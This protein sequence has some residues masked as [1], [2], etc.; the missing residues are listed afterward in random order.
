M[1]IYRQIIA[2]LLAIGGNVAV[3]TD[4]ELVALS[5]VAEALPSLAPWKLQDVVPSECGFAGAADPEAKSANR[6]DLE[7]ELD[8]MGS[9]EQADE[10]QR[11][12]LAEGQGCIEVADDPPITL[13]VACRS[14]VRADGRQRLFVT[15]HRGRV[16]AR[17][18]LS[19]PAVAIRPAEVKAVA[20]LAERS[21]WFADDEARLQALSHC[22]WLHGEAVQKLLGTTLFRQQAGR[23][24]TCVARSSLGSLSVV[25]SEADLA[26]ELAPG[27]S[28]DCAR[29]AVSELGEFGSFTYDCQDILGPLSRVH[30][31]VG[32]KFVEYT[33]RPGRDPTT[34]ERSLLIQVAKDA[35][36]AAK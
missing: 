5:A 2:M 31:I 10:R 32:D 4:C 11:A 7:I 14:P 1:G 22:P 8:L 29:E 26:P 6:V 36:A 17:A 27:A 25:T 16:L 21:L 34:A 28:G 12:Q 20:E 3:A 35:H 18:T 9:P 19:A 23:Y 13:A 24:E 15:T 30:A 33:F